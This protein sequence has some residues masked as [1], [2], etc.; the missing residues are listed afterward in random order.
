MMMLDRKYVL[1]IP[2][3]RFGDGELV[4]IDI[5]EILEDLVGRLDCESFYMTKVRGCYRSR[6]FDELLITV[7]ASDR[8]I[9]EIFGEWFKSNNDV[10]GQE[11]F[12]YECGDRMFV[13]MLSSELTGRMF[14]DSEHCDE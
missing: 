12:S 6:V 9:G 7:F 3:C 5:D 10:L 4:A 14:Y 8:D 13:E 1:H 11:A 2:L